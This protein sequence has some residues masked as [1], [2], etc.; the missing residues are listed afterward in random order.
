VFCKK[1]SFESPRDIKYLR[2]TQIAG[3]IDS[4]SWCLGFLLALVRFLVMPDFRLLRF[5]FILESDGKNTPGLR[6]S[7]QLVSVLVAHS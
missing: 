7:L 1:F 3:L 4:T 6:V 2:V 5:D